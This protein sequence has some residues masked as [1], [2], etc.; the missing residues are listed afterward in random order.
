MVV[1]SPPQISLPLYP[2][3]R[4]VYPVY[5]ACPVYAES[6]SEPRR[7]PRSER[8]RKALRARSLHRPGRGVRRLLRPGRLVGVHPERLESFSS[9]DLCPFNFRL[10]TVN[11]LP[12]SHRIIFF[13]H[14]YPLTPIESYSCKKQGEGVPL[15]PSRWRGAL[16]PCATR[17]NA[18]N[19]NHFIRLLHNSRTPRGGELSSKEGV[20]IF[21]A[22][23]TRNTSH[24]TRA[25]ELGPLLTTSLP[26]THCSPLKP[27]LQMAHPYTCTRKKGPAARE[28]RYSTCAAS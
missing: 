26:T 9:P 24:G 14:P 16:C 25:T 10:S 28:P 7:E 4:R 18:R 23:S 13:A 5:P 3:E 6:R 11:Y 17:R 20:S 27:L 1:A 22:T 15:T 21:L 2:E 12:N 8:T 19:F